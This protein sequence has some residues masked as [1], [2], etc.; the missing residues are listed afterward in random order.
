[1]TAVQINY[2]DFFIILLTIILGYEGYRSGFFR[3][4][5]SIGGIFIS[6]IITLIA[7][8]HSARFYYAVIELSP[9]ISIVMGFVTIIVICL[10]LHSL[11]LQWLHTIMK[12]EVVDW[13]NR[14]SGTLLGLFKGLL[15]LSLL[16]LGFS[17]LPL[18]EQIKYAE[19][20]S[21]FFQ[22]VK[23]FMPANY[24]F[25][26]K[27]VPRTPSFEEALA[28]TLAT[29]GVPEETLAATMERFKCQGSETSVTTTP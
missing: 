20:S 12:M 25:F 23:C 13:F 19:E 27:L 14:I 29:L 2:V 18:P 5:L 16:A 3:G 22:P 17:C 28:K 24:N 1:M 21:T 11:F 9:N 4:I 7:L 15:I 10:L 8:P 6:L 26:H